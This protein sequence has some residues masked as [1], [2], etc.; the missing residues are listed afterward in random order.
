MRCN[1]GSAR[2]TSDCG[3][4]TRTM[5]RKHETDAPSAKPASTRTPCCCSGLVTSWTCCPT[6][7]RAGG[8]GGRRAAGRAPCLRSSPPPKFWQNPAN[9][10]STL[11]NTD[12]AG[13]KVGDG[14]FWERIDA[15]HKLIARDAM[16]KPQGV[17]SSAKRNA[18]SKPDFDV[19]A[20]LRQERLDRGSVG[21]AFARGQV[22]GHGDLLWN[23]PTEVVHPPG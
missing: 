11:L 19:P 3:C 4:R 6:P 16:S 20:K 15:T 22:D 10:H 12:A 18:S 17:N 1:G 2:R 5:I 9:C 13:L 23:A 14:D 8:G 7:G 21:E